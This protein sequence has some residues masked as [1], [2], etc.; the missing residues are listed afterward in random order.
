MTPSFIIQQAVDNYQR[1]YGQ[2]QNASLK[3][4]PLYIHAFRVEVKSFSGIVSYLKEIL[5]TPHNGLHQIASSLKPYYKSSG[6]VRNIT[7]IQELLL[8]NK[9]TLFNPCF[10][11][12]LN[13]LMDVR[14]SNFMA[15]SS[16]IN[17]PT[18]I[19]LSAELNELKSTPLDYDMLFQTHLQNNKLKAHELITSNE[20]GEPWH[21]A[22]AFFKRNYLL[23]KLVSGE[24]EDAVEMSE[25]R[26]LE[27]ELGSWHDLIM[28]EKAY[29]KFISVQNRDDSSD[30]NFLEVL[31][32]LKL[33]HI[34]EI[35]A[36][37]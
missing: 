22:R 37:L 9:E 16:V 6:K 18:A 19:E 1:L 35:R 4:D 2:L 8:Q 14:L 23:L 21:N 7:V 27:Q 17:L 36:L 31:E 12:H 25:S 26:V 5:N 13:D 33:T 3:G 30:L 15:I 10:S 24:I 28:L 11:E 20:A 34:N 32:K 29:R